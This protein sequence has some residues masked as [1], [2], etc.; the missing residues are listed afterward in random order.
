MLSSGAFLFSVEKV[1]VAKTSRIVSAESTILVGCFGS[2]AWVRVEGAAN[3]E[4]AGCIRDFLTGRFEKGW[5]QFV[6]DLEDCRGIDSTFIGILYRLAAK[7]SETDSG[8]SVEV[9]NPGERNAKSISKLGLDSLIKIDREGSRWKEERELVAKNLTKPYHCA[10]LEKKEKTQLV[11]EA[12][13]ALLAAN[14]ENRSRF[15][16]VVE[17]LRQDLEA[18]S[19]EG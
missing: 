14:E 2:V 3:Y 19:K 11:L 9:I 8:G 13:E 7:V 12:H 15:C 5:R 4:N 10:P 18:Q 17:F 1:P 16:D 6:V